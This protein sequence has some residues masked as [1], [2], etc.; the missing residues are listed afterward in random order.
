MQHQLLKRRP[1]LRNHQQ[2]VRLAPGDERLLD[3]T[4][5]GNKLLALGQPQ[6]DDRSIGAPPGRLRRAGTGTRTRP[7]VE[8]T[9]RVP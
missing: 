9:R 2:P 5:P 1:A 6:L 4:A 3:R 8:W 7:P